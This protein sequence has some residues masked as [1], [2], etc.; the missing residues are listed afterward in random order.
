[1]AAFEQAVRLRPGMAELYY[2]LGNTLIDQL[3]MEEASRA[4]EE[5]I[6]LKPTWAEG[7]FH[8]GLTRLSMGDFGRGWPEYEWRTGIR[9]YGPVRNYTEP[10]WD[11]KE[12][13]GKTILLH[14]EQ[15]QGDTIHFVRY[16]PMVADR[17][18]AKMGGRVILGC[19]QS[20]ARLLGQVAGM[21][22]IIAGSAQTPR[23]DV[24]CRLLS[25]PRAFGTDLQSI[26]ATSP[27]LR[28][29]AELSKV[30][31]QKMGARTAGSAGTKI[32]VGL[33]WAGSTGY[34]HNFKRSL[35]LSHLA[36][37]GEIPGITLYSIQ[38]GEGT[39]QIAEMGPRM[40]LIDL[41]AE[42]S[43][44]ADT[45]AL[46]DNLDLVITVDTAVAH[47]ATA[48]GKPTWIMLPYS[49]DWRWMLGREDSPWYPT[50]WLV[51]QPKPG[52]WGTVVT[53][54]VER[55]KDFRP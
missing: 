22:Q 53:R 43:D 33:R 38:K 41:T 27:Y 8:L 18:G 55:L 40:T 32:R 14:D 29:D 25:L 48:M 6:R 31:A 39:E 44:F 12:L 9:G 23:F 10:Q 16:V 50:A 54:I 26:P 7:H 2:N 1:V 46:I 3:R 35:T 13:E 20:L 24:H 36:P 17:V 51:R 19:Q 28:A 37:L 42:L 52:D 47:L 21:D 15:G 30:W 34:A 4:F 49:P 5:V 11:G 45:A